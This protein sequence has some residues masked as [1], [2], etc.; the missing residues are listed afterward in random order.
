[1]STLILAQFTDEFFGHVIQVIK[2]EKTPV[3]GVMFVKATLKELG[4]Q[5]CFI[6]AVIKKLRK[7]GVI[8]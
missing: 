8:P 6:N 2:T 3:Q 4:Y 7:K 1:M 5:D